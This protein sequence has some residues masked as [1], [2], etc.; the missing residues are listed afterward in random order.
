MILIFVSMEIW[1]YSEQQIFIAFD[2]EKHVFY[3]FFLQRF[4]EENLW[5]WLL[6]NMIFIENWY[7]FILPAH[8]VNKKDAILE[9]I[10][11]IALFVHVSN[12]ALSTKRPSPRTPTTIPVV[13]IKMMGFFH[14]VK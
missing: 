9:H 3:I 6:Y 13:A 4:F 11:R 14:A 2:S 8:K 5:T 10:G 1:L 12:S 7:K